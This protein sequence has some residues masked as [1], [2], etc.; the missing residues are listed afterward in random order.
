MRVVAFE[1]AVRVTLRDA[2]LLD[3]AD[4]TTLFAADALDGDA[5]AVGAVYEAEA[6]VFADGAGVGP[7]VSVAGSVD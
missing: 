7:R 2:G 6:G 1:R 5:V 3:G 4:G